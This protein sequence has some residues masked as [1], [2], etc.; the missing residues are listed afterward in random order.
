MF[1][2]GSVRSVGSKRLLSTSPMSATSRAVS[3][4]SCMSPT[5][6]AD[7]SIAGSHPLSHLMTAQAR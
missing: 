2:A 4:M 1:V 3:G 5:A 6:P 7:D